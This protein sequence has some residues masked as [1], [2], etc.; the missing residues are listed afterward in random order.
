MGKDG[1]E[2]L[3]LGGRSPVVSK[4]LVQVL[5]NHQGGTKVFGEKKTAEENNS[6]MN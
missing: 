2:N 1:V 4:V 5:L 3:G 6:K